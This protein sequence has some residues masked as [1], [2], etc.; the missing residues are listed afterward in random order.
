MSEEVLSASSLPSRLARFRNDLL[1]DAKC[2]D[3]EALEANLTSLLA[4]CGQLERE[5]RELEADATALRAAL[6]AEWAAQL[7]DAQVLED[8]RAIIRTGQMHVQQV[9][10]GEDRE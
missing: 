8:L 10:E 4:Y 9:K 6:E 5:R 3:Y 2:G 1:T 7:P